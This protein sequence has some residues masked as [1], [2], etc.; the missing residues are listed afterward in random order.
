MNASIYVRTNDWIIPSQENSYEI[1]NRQYI[2]LAHST[3]HESPNKSIGK[4][5]YEANSE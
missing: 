1:R 4:V 2:Y 5:A 3:S